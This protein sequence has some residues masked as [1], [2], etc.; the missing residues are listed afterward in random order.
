MNIKVYADESGVFDKQNQ[1]YFVYA[2]FS[3]RR[4]R[5][6]GLEISPFLLHSR[7]VLVTKQNESIEI[8]MVLHMVELQYR[9]IKSCI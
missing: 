4:Y 9:N 3:Q 2:G 8:S 1:K 5:E 7:Y 6:K